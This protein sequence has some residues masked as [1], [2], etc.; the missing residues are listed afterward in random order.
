MTNFS[1]VNN[2]VSDIPC[3]QYGSHDNRIT[4]YNIII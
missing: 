1:K 2:N 3:P 4:D